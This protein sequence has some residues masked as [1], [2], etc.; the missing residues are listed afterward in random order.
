MKLIHQRCSNHA[1]REAVARCPE[2]GQHFCREC[3]TEHEDR[4]ICAPCLRAMTAP[5]TG[6][7]RDLAWLR[8]GLPSALG[9]LAAWLFF[10]WLG[11]GLLA[12]PSA[13]HDANVWSSFWNEW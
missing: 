6:R 5:A 12:I 9:V 3:V 13:F 1:A 11:K 2:C 10:Y 4:L 8:Q 7:R